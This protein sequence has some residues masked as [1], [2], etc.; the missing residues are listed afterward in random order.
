MEGPVI[1][2][3]TSF[4][5]T[6]T[7][8]RKF[9]PLGP[10]DINGTAGSDTL[11]GT[12]STDSIYGYAGNDYL[13]GLAGGDTLNGGAG[14]DVMVG[15]LGDD[16]YYVD[17]VND[18]V[19]EWGGEGI[20]A[21]RVS[22]YYQWYSLPTAVE[23]AQVVGSDPVGLRGNEL[24]NVLTGNAAY[25]ALDGWGGN[26]IL[27]GGDGDQYDMLGGGDGDD[28]L[29]G[30]GGA[31]FMQGGQ[32]ND[33]Y[34]IDNYDD[35]I[36]EN[37]GAGIDTIRSRSGARNE[38]PDHVENLELSPSQT[39]AYAIGNA[40][41]NR[42]I[43]NATNNA[44]TGGGGRDVMY[45]GL[46]ADTFKFLSVGEA[47][48]LGYGFTDYIPDFSEAEGDKIDLSLIDAN[49]L[50]AGDQAFGFIGNGAFTGAAGELRFNTTFGFVEGDVTGDAVADFQIEI[51]LTGIGAGAFI[52]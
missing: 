2:R 36:I 13:Y 24:D 32:G 30:E 4:S 46:G 20:D 23:N 25:N 26:D 11:Y 44:I 27:F 1:Y 5:T 47:A 14:A 18:V 29:D 51:D 9:L 10:N 34:Y 37:A 41:D 48:A 7:F 45:G 39:N 21:V 16:I 42:I 38:L 15:G 52:L 17:D 33:I 19:W 35:L 49:F 8:N 22:L 3:A 40:L 43:A 28:I 31:D 50:V 12:S 6:Y